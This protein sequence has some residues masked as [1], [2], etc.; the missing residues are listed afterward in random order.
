MCYSET[1]PMRN[2][3]L[4]AVSICALL[5]AFHANAVETTTIPL[6]DDLRFE[7]GFTVWSPVPGRKT[8]QG[9]IVPGTEA[10]SAPPVWSLAQWHS[11]FTLAEAHREALPD[12]RVRFADG[13]KAVTFFPSGGEASISLA[14]NALTEYQGKASSK[15]DPWPHLLAERELLAHPAIHEIVSVPFLIRYRLVKAETHRPVG[16]DPRR[17][18]AQFVFYLTVQNRDRK[19]PGYGDYFWFGVPLYDAR[20]RIPKAHK[21]MD[22][23]SDRKPATGKFIFNPG[24]D[25]YTSDSAHDGDWV[26][27][28][29]D[30]APLIREGLETAWELGFL[31][32]SRNPADY[33]LM[34]MNTGWEVTGPLNVEVEIGTLRL[35]AEVGGNGERP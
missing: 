33:R 27:I 35:D 24:G 1:L 19:S 26:T 34:A 16:F 25:R 4:A 13:A 18:T 3:I 5:P 23:G 12:G 10:R 22:K 6:L 7:R 30:L 20:Y 31:Q 11:R 21:A 29:R 9:T 28:D 8:E 14:V 32:D 17:H 2:P 15:G